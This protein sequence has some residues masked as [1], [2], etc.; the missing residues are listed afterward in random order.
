MD[1]RDETTDQFLIRYRT[2]PPEQSLMEE[3]TK[4]VG[5]TSIRVGLKP[6]FR[7][8]C[9]EATICA[10]DVYDAMKQRVFDEDEHGILYFIDQCPE[11]NW[12]HEC[13]YVLVLLP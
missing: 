7:A 11:A 5:F 4:V 1:P 8:F 6:G 2:W 10:S 3:M 9:R 13:V 12:A